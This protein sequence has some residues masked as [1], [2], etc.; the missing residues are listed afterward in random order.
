MA[1][2]AKIKLEAERLEVMDKAAGILAELLY[3]ENMLAEV[4]EY[5]PIMIHVRQQWVGG[6]GGQGVLNLPLQYFQNR[7]FLH[8]L[9]WGQHLLQQCLE[10]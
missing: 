1:N 8:K 7:P 3:T 5:R 2:V 6:A 9:F 10:P 4:K